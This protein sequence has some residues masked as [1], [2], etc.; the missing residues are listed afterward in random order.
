MDE[1][2]V[3]RYRGR[4][5][6]TDLQAV[7]GPPQ[8]WCKDLQDVPVGFGGKAIGVQTPVKQAAFSR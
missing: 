1:E 2:S 8:S 6:Y 4:I 7:V 5:R 3:G